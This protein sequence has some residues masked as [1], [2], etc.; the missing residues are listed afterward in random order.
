M[1]KPF[2]AGS[3]LKKSNEFSSSYRTLSVYLPKNDNQNNL[4][5]NKLNLIKMS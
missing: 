2:N 1:K 5:N 3:T 4:L